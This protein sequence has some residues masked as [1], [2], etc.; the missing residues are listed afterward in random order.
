MADFQY[1]PSHYVPFRDMEAVRR[2]R[3]IKAEDM[4]KHPNPDFKIH[5]MPA[6]EIESV[7]VTDI[8]QRILASDRDDQRVVMILPNPVPTY[9][10]VAKLINAC[11]V[12]CRNLWAFA[13]DEYANEK[14]ETAPE[15]WP[16]GFTYAMLHNLYYQIDE[17]LRPPR[18]QFVA[19][20][21]KNINDYSKMIEDAGGAD[22]C[23]SGPGWTGHLAFVD[24]D[25]PEWDAPLEQWKKM[26]TRISTLSPFTIAQNSMHGSFGK[27]GDLTAVPPKAA[28]IGPLDV[29]NAKHR[30]DMH[31]ISVHGTTT[32]WQRMITRLC[33]H[34]PVTPKV[35]GSIHQELRT[36]CY[37][38]TIAAQNIEPDWEKGY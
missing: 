1:S 11:R 31:A 2:C 35:P 4:D 14:D 12:N 20:N 27:S 21:T 29:I 18:E 9:R 38:S 10:K 33:L 32:S 23:Y 26:G 37:V 6:D 25:A 36:D 16:F 22:I 13:M 7:L 28:T 3:A 5:V 30:F 17:D 15:D 19:P 34:G 24:P 8:F